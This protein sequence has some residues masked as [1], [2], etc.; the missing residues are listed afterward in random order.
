M[1][2]EDNRRPLPREVYIRRRIAAVV[3]LVAVIGVIW[4]LISLVSG[5]EESENTAATESA[6]TTSEQQD[7]SS[8]PEPPKGADPSESEAKASE[9]KESEAKASEDKKKDSC[10]LADLKVTARP[11][12]TTFNADQ[13][14]NFYAR[15]ENPTGADCDINL[16]DAPL[17]FEVFT[18]GNYQ[19]V[20]GD[21]DCN[22]PEVTG[23]VKIKA[24]EAVNYELA[25]WSRTTSAPGQCEARQPVDPG[26]YLLYTHVGD[27]TSQP[28][29]FNLQ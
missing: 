5:G 19:R 18:M 17:K 12:A 1:T 8:P 11:G 10:S 3:I 22:A 23:D 20:W 13:Q 7:M 25:G 16:D 6:T 9:S 21:I 2:E 15:I 14:P 28:A 27:N 24:G 29:S 4:G 26:S